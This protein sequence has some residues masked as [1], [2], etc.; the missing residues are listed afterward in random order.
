MNGCRGNIFSTTTIGTWR[1]S[2]LVIMIPLEWT[3]TPYGPSGED[4][5]HA[6]VSGVQAWDHPL[7]TR[8]SDVHKSAG[9]EWEE[10][11]ATADATNGLASPTCTGSAPRFWNF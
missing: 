4:S 9:A 7:S 3:C 8:S 6:I 5:R 11:D 10:Y 2:T 1:R